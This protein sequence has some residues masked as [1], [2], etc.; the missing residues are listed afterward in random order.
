MKD[1]DMPCSTGARLMVGAPGP[2]MTDDYKTFSR[3]YGICNFILFS[4][5]IEDEGQLRALCAELHALARENSGKGALIAID[6][7]G[8]RVQRLPKAMLDTPPAGE[9]A[10]SG[11]EKRVYDAG[12]LIAKTLRGLGVN[13][14]LAPVMD[15]DC[16]NGNPVVRDRSFGRT[17]GEAAKYGCAMLRGLMDGA[18]LA[19]AKHFPG[20]GGTH[21]D[22]HKELPAIDFTLEELREGHLVPF[23]AALKAGV[24][25]VM[26][27][28][29]LFPNIDAQYPSTMSRRLLTGELREEMGFQGVVMTDCLEMD[30]VG[31][32]YG[33][34]KAAV[35]AAAAGADL[36]LVS[37]T[38]AL[39]AQCAEELERAIADKELNGREHEVSL[40][41]IWEAKTWLA[42]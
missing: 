25:A 24:R 14:N 16:Q 8:G 30:A 23:R 19:C 39:A 41:R 4:D 11:D 35:R 2:Y 12:L 1:M 37:H 6:Q 9:L 31:K 28:H 13:F 26:S 3:K 18:V 15:V 21:I 20:H 10:A 17:P 40:D 36:L 34:K 33:A 27:A 7:E 32:H 38:Q 42:L 22:T 29:I 5:D